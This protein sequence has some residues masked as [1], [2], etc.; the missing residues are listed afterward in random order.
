MSKCLWLLKHCESVWSIYV[1]TQALYPSH[2]STI[3]AHLSLLD[4]EWMRLLSDSCLSPEY[5][6]LFVNGMPRKQVLRARARAF[7]AREKHL[8]ARFVSANP[9][10]WIC[11]KTCILKNVVLFHSL[12]I[13]HHLRAAHATSQKSHPAFYQK[14]ISGKERQERE[15]ENKMTL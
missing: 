2:R 5:S 13:E 6:L 9:T 11:S 10:N 12:F 4:R 8:F 15:G 1:K 7:L 3:P 14:P